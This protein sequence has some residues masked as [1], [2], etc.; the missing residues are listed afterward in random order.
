MRKK[1]VT[2]LNHFENYREIPQKGPNC[3]PP[4]GVKKLKE[5]QFQGLRPGLLTRGFALDSAGAPPPDA[6]YMLALSAVYHLLPL[7]KSR[8][9]LTEVS[10]TAVLSVNLV[11]LMVSALLS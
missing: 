8:A 7:F 2:P 11:A 3:R 5:F 1:S 4:L 10:C 9:P 6:L